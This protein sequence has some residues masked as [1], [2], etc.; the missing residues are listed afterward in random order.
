MSDLHQ[1]WQVI[2]A[3][4]RI[5]ES[6]DW[7]SEIP[8]LH[9]PSDWDVQLI[10]PFSGALVRFRVNPTVESIS[11]YL[12]GYERLGIFDGPYWEVYPY[13]DDVARFAMDDTDGLLAAIQE[14]IDGEDSY[15]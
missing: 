10:P 6:R 3:W 8:A 9:F 1:P 7:I 4:D 11:V 13:A 5:Q 14:V 12:D 15:E 2:S